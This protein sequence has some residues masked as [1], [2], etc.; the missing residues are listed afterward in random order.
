MVLVFLLQGLARDYFDQPLWSAMREASYGHATLDF[1]SSSTA[2]F[3]WH[4]NQVCYCLATSQNRLIAT[5]SMYV[6]P[7]YAT[8]AAYTSFP[9]GRS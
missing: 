6:M 2:T 8:K 7:P 9:L 4:R 5:K 3:R 1:E